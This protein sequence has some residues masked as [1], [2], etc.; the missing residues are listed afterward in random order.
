MLKDIL[1]LVAGLVLIVK[2]GEFFVAAAMRLAE[3]LR[4]PR[5]VIGSTLVSL[6]TTCPE[7]VV[8]V[9]S[10]LRGESGLAVGN[11]DRSRPWSVSRIR[12]PA[13]KLGSTSPASTFAMR[14]C[15]TDAALASC[16]CVRPSFCLSL[17]TFSEMWPIIPCTIS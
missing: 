13:E 7:M 17:F 16:S 3:F 15:E 9:T 11:A 14:L 5:V 4:M 1:L 10:G 8:S 2:G 6:A 12:L